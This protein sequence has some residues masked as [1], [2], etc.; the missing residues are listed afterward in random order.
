MMTEITAISAGDNKLSPTHPGEIL[1]DE[2]EGLCLS[3]AEFA[4]RIGVPKDRVHQIIHARRSI[5]AD[6]A[7]RLGRYFGTGPQVW[8][9]LQESY[10]LKRAAEKLGLELEKITPRT[11]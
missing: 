11:A 4:R 1:Q 7:L 8:M 9:R 3:L 5:S 6:T 10:D 2:I